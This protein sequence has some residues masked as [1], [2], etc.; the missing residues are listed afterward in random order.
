MIHGLVCF[1]ALRLPVQQKDLSQSAKRVGLCVTSYWC[2]CRC[3]RALPGK[4][5]S[6]K[7]FH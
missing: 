7:T 5:E 6:H 3:C 1:L 2:I 4:A